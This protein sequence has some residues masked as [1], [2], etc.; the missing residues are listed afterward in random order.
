ML[1]RSR[2][3]SL[4]V[5]SPF[6]LAKASPL[7]QTDPLTG[8]ID[9]DLL[10]SGQS[11]QQRKLRGDLRREV[12]QLLEAKDKGMRW[13]DLI[14]AMEGQSSLAIDNSEF[15]EV[16]KAVSPFCGLRSGPRC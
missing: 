13:N 3:S 7:P 5:H 10:N 11:L 9:L 12:L 15:S 14:K 4:P 8:L 2:R 6:S 1:F 16:I